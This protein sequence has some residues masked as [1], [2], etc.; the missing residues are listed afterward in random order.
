MAEAPHVTAPED[1]RR[2][3]TPERRRRRIGEVLVEQ[4]LLTEDQ[5]GQ[6]LELQRT[7]PPGSPRP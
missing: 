5:V 2:T 7:I 1:D 3:G 4:G 6:A